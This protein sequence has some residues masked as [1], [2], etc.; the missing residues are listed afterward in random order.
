M[1]S[2]SQKPEIDTCNGSYVDKIKAYNNKKCAF[3]NV[4][5]EGLISWIT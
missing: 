5:I 4:L 1:V 2:P 3:N